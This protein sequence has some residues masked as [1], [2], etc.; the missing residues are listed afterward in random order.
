[1]ASGISAIGGRNRQIVVVV[2]VAERAGHIGV[3]GSEQE[4]GRAVIEFG[5]RPIVKCMAAGAVRSGECCPC[6]CVR[7]IGCVLPVRYMARRACRRKPQVI[8]DRLIF[9]TIHALHD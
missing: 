3:S 9:V 5:V 7:R 6:G 2:D 4:P 1:M 8:S